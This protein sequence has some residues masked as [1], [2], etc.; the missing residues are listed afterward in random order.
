MGS[1]T[2]GTD[3]SA[4][5]SL[6]PQ[7]GALSVPSAEAPVPTFLVSRAGHHTSTPQVQD[8]ALL[9]GCQTPGKCS[10]RAGMQRGWDLH[11][12]CLRPRGCVPCR[13]VGCRAQGS[14]GF[15][16]TLARSWPQKCR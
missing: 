4:S 1:L 5:P 12:S 7:A 10:S 2:W 13:P 15:R 9:G 14:P 8:Q 11:G 3:S 16:M 6:A